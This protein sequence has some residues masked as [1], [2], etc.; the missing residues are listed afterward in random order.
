M[1]DTGDTTN[2]TTWWL[3]ITNHQNK[4]NKKN[5][6]I[7]IDKI[8]LYGSKYKG[9]VKWMSQLVYKL[10]EEIHDGRTTTENKS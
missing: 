8:H 9:K 10:W 2:F 1:N 6:L 4:K 5:A 3:S 7:S